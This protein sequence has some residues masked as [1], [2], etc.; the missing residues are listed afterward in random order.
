M[1]TR[2]PMPSSQTLLSGGGTVALCRARHNNL[3]PH[4]TSGG[5]D[6]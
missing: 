5:F 4:P 2:L 3:N 6:A 1:A